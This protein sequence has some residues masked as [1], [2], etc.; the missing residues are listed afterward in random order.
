MALSTA[1][2][3]LQ[4][5]LN[6]CWSQSI[7]TPKLVQ[8]E[9]NLF[10]AAF[11]VMKVLPAIYILKKAMQ[12]QEVTSRSVIVE[13][14]SGTFALGL[15]IV[16][17]ELKLPLFVASDPAID[18]RLRN[19]LES[20]NARVHIVENPAPGGGYQQPR[21]DVVKQFLAKNPNAYWTRQY[22]NGDNPDSYKPFADYLIETFGADF[23]LVGSVGSGG[24]TVGTIRHLRRVNPDISLAGV[25][26]YDSVLFGLPDG[27]RLL[28]G[29][30]NSIM[31]KNL[32]HRCYDE[33]H[34]VS[35]EQAFLA[36]HQLHNK[37]SVFGGP[38]SGAAFMVARYLAK[39]NPK[40]TVVFISA[41]DGERY[42][43]TIFSHKWLLEKGI[44]LNNIV[45]RTQPRSVDSLSQVL[46]S[47]SPWTYI[48]WQRRTLTQ[49]IQSQS[50]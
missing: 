45:P 2:Q 32:D 1:T 27:H 25:D 4:K 24:S 44:A 12:R 22:D 47:V 40:K 10:V 7:A 34:W 42:L 49:V 31:P 23:T 20:L 18:Q 48:P 30:G 19:R 35:A 26:T 29:L 14:S 5:S 6:T 15:A 17:N 37:H 38:T 3:P 9:T 28:R 39:R 13:T 8:V 16:C 33:V 21:L 50:K 43:S 36:T 11:S 46:K 41:D